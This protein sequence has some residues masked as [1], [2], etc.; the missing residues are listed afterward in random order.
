MNQEIRDNTVGAA[1]AAKLATQALKSSV[2]LM[3][4]LCAKICKNKAGITLHSR[5]C[6]K[7]KSL[8]NSYVKTTFDCSCGVKCKTA[9]GLGVHTR[10]KHEDEFFSEQKI[11]VKARW[12]DDEVNFWPKMNPS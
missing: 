5:T 2:S 1:T 3:Y 7:K 8:A 4:Q 6:Q 11:G 9:A 10:N 12:T